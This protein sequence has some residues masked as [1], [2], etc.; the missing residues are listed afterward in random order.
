MV[1]AEWTKHVKS[2]EDTVGQGGLR[3]HSNHAHC[4]TSN[5]RPSTITEER[6]QSTLYVKQ[7]TRDDSDSVHIVTPGFHFLYL[8]YFNHHCKSASLIS[9]PTDQQRPS[10]CK[11]TS[12]PKVRQEVKIKKRWKQAPRSRREVEALETVGTTGT[13]TDEVMS[14]IYR[15]KSEERRQGREGGIQKSCRSRTWTCML[16][17]RSV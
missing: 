3:V 6:P 8:V 15:E 4:R 14:Q 10:G 11:D 2:K 1:K 7:T 13:L 12:I 16:P 9:W 5:S 17:S